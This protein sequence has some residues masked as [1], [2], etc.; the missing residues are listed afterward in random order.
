MEGLVDILV[1]CLAALVNASLQLELG[2]LLLLYHESLGKHIRKVTRKLTAFY[3]IGACFFTMLLMF[4]TILII[5]NVC[6]G[7]LDRTWL[8][9]CSAIMAIIAVL[10]LFFYYKPG[11]N[12]MLWIP[13]PVARYLENRAKRTSAAPEGIALGMMTSLGELPFSIIL[14]VIAAN[15]IINLPQEFTILA[16]AV[17]ALI[18]VMP[19]IITKML[20]K[21]GRTVVDIQRWRVKNKNFLKVFSVICYITLAAFVVV[22]KVLENK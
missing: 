12:T 11:K 10:T 8:I 4:G 17:Y 6:N 21:S 13:S 5:L 15:S 14:I 18:S 3:I 16:V 9:F 2:T 22:F 7:Q 19:L 1:I 20:I